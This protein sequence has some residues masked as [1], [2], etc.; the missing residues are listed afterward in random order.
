M[1]KIYVPWQISRNA[2]QTPGEIEFNLRFFLVNADNWE[3]EFNLSTLSA[4]SKI[5]SSITYS[6]LDLDSNEEISEATDLDELLQRVK[7]IEREYELYWI[8]LD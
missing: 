6:K 4:K 5:L 2:T 8:E 7:R 1:G 3:Y